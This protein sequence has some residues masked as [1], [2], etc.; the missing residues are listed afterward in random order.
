MVPSP[1]LIVPLPVNRFSN[2]LAPTVPNNIPRNSPFCYFAFILIVSPTPF[3]NKPDSLRDL[4]ILMI[5]FISSLEII[6]VAV[7]DPNIFLWIAASVAKAAAAA[8]I[9]A[10]EAAAVAVPNG[11]K[12]L[13]ANDLH[14]FLFKE[15]SVFINGHKSQPNKIVYLDCLISCN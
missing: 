1:A 8:A 7:P 14:I 15:N 12:T 11:I 2:K 6:N 3:I 13:L 10:A 9:V 4:T 5:S